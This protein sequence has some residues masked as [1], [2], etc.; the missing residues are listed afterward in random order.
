MMHYAVADAFRIHVVRE[1][2]YYKII[3]LDPNHKVHKS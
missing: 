3:R 1:D 2:G